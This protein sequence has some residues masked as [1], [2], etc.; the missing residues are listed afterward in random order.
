MSAP[1]HQIHRVLTS[2]RERKELLILACG[3]DR[4]AWRHACR[5]ARPPGA[6]FARDLLGHLETFS[7]VLPRRHGRWLRGA[8]LITGLVRQL[9]WLRL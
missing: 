9:G 2:A 3:V 4:M 1:A 6:R 5:P 7:A 8:S